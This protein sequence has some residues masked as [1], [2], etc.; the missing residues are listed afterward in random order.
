M[1]EV[2]PRQTLWFGLI[3]ASAVPLNYYAYCDLAG[4]PLPPLQSQKDGTK[5]LLFDKDLI[6]ATKYMLTGKLNPLNWLM[7]Y[8]GVKV[9]A[10]WSWSDLRPSLS[11]VKTYLHRIKT[12]FLGGKKN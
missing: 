10:V 1:V 11:V 9:R 2:N 12:R 3:G 4:L 7:S 8:R 5:W 6:T